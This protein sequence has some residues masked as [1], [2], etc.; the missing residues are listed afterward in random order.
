[1]KN[2]AQTSSKISFIVFIISLMIFTFLFGLVTASFEWFPFPYFQKAWYTAKNLWQD[3]TTLHNINPA[4]YPDKT[5]VLVYKK[6]KVYPGITLISGSWNPGDEDWY[7]GIQLVDLDGNLVHQWKLDPSKIWPESPHTDHTA[8]QHNKKRKTMIHGTIIY[9]NGDIVFNFEYLTLVRMDW[10]GNIIWKL[11]YRTH[12]SVFE[13]E[14]GSLWV[15]GAKWREE[16]VPEYPHL[17]PNYTED[18]IV[19]VSPDGDIKREIS[20][21]KVLYESNYYGLLFFD[22]VYNTGDVT[23]LNN[24]EVL[25][26]EMAENFKSFNAG[27]ILVSM[28]YINTVMVIDG[29]TEK[30]KWAMTHPFVAQHDPDFYPDGTITVFNNGLSKLNADSVLGGSEILKIDPVTNSITPI[31]GHKED[32]YFYTNRGGKHQHLPNGNMIITEC[33]AGRVFEVTSSGELVWDWHTSKW[34]KINV[35][36]VMQGTRLPEGYLTFLSN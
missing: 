8:G 3:A 26:T 25:S 32:Q 16:N 28:R 23:H 17:Y 29:I 14:N 21:L 12:H 13:D 15:C 10:D 19:K 30:V 4:R 36:E 1:M 22:W 31:Y 35:S 2:N 18:M 24:V 5:G 27:D 9:P 7:Y 34:D 6:D 20:I 33:M 11:P